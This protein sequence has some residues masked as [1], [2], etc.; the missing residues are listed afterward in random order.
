MALTTALV[1]GAS[2]GIGY[3]ISKQLAEQGHD[4]VLVARR[5]ERLKQLATFLERE[6][7]ISV[8]VIAIDLTD[9]HQIDQLYTTL[10]KENIPVDILVNNAGLGNWGPFTANDPGCELKEIQLNVTAL[11]YLTK[12]FATDMVKRGLGK[13]LNIASVSG[14]MPGPYMAV[15]N[16]TKAYVVSFSEALKAELKGTGVSVTVSCPGPTA[17]EFHQMAG[18][19][20]ANFL[21]L[22][23]MMTSTQ[24]AKISLAAMHKRK[25]VVV[26]GLINKLMTLTPRVTPRPILMFVLK[27]LMKPRAGNR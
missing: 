15:Y 25:V 26:P 10:E 3:E 11:T 4:L 20:T 16:A 14:F 2:S 22:M 23:P 24:V 21:K 9:I 27:L 8:R 18:T 12:L 19:T 1:T 6:H 5:E 7:S 17:S 13:V